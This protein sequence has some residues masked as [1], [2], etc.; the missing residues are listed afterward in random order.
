MSDTIEMIRVEVVCA[1]CGE[2]YWRLVEREYIDNPHSWRVSG[3][4]VISCSGGRGCSSAEYIE[5][6]NWRAKEH[7][8]LKEVG[9]G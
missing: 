2:I 8:K 6:R 1:Y 9:N 5:N 3:Y 7:S 4:L